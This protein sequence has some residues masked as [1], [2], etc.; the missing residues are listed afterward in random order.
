MFE[1]KNRESEVI[2]FLNIL[3]VSAVFVSINFLSQVIGLYFIAIIYL[4]LKHYSVLKPQLK[5]NLVYF[6]IAYLPFLIL[7]IS[8]FWSEDLKR[9]SSQLFKRLPLII[10]PLGIF[11]QDKLFKL[12]KNKLIKAYII[13]SSVMCLYGIITIFMYY[14]INYEANLAFIHLRFLLAEKILFMHPV[15]IG[16]LCGLASVFSF[17]FISFHKNHNKPKRIFFF[18]L[19]SINLATMLLVSSRMALLALIASICFI[20]IFHKKYKYSIVVFVIILT[21]IMTLQL[22]LPGYRFVEIISI[23]KNFSF[24]IHNINSTLNFRV[25]IYRCVLNLMS[26]SPIIGYGIGDIQNE[27]F[28]CTHDTLGNFKY[29]THNQYFEFLLVGGVLGLIGF[30]V[31]LGHLFSGYLK[32]HNY[33]GCSVLIFFIIC[34]LTEN[35]LVRTRGVFIFSYSIFLLNNYVYKKQL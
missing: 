6:G 4:I 34:F 24:N 20:L 14:P 26:N 7:L 29:N 27:L 22:L 35:I 25:E 17:H 16:I 12:N 8:M 15:Y 13:A 23:V 11:V 3:L 31:F 28:E 19:G 1:L 33:L 10:F 21:L 5:T 9:G 30:L 32:S 2:Y 18:I